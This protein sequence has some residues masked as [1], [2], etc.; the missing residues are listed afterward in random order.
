MSDHLD[1]FVPSPCIGICTMEGDFCAGC[2]RTLDEIAS[3][4]SLSNEQKR[5]TVA[6]LEKRKELD[7]EGKLRPS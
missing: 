2:Y 7:R 1:G 4:S 3:W 5:A 6:E